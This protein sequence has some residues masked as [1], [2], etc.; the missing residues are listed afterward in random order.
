[1]FDRI[2]VN[3]KICRREKVR[4]F[5]CEEILGGFLDSGGAAMKQSTKGGVRRDQL[6]SLNFLIAEFLEKTPTELSLEIG[7]LPEGQWEY[8]WIDLFFNP[9]E[10]KQWQESTKGVMQK[11]VS[12]YRRV[13][14]ILFPD[15]SGDFDFQQ[16]KASYYED[17]QFMR[18]STL[19]LHRQLRE[20]WLSIK[21]N[22]F[23]YKEFILSEDD[24]AR[25]TRKLLVSSFP[26]SD[27][28]NHKESSG[29]L[30][31]F[32][33]L[34]GILRE[35]KSR[36]FSV[37]RFEKHVKEY[38][39]RLYMEREAM[40]IKQDSWILRHPLFKILFNGRTIKFADRLEPR[41]A[42]L[43]LL[44]GLPISIFLEC[45]ECGRCFVE[46]KAGKMY[47]THLCAATAG[48]KRRWEKD[49][50]GAR[51]KERIRYQDKRKR[52][53]VSEAEKNETTDDSNQ[54][55]PEN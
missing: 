17:T 47:C 46:T 1:M 40:D 6:V 35:L 37:Q 50:A 20:V 41:E 27:S 32:A 51:K 42:L 48:Q 54:Q 16:H 12:I 49:P 21:W 8:N 28:Q 38:P 24:E 23:A 22:I 26:P 34:E 30:H 44:D 11:A 5:F 45:P 4:D 33:D 43:D 31:E 52:Q 13:I 53:K 18:D 25:E 3:G 2:S 36:G 15:F 29:D 19:L 55:G 39:K 14:E 10:Y 9:E 7:K